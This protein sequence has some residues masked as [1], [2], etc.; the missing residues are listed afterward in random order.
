[1][2]TGGSSATW[3]SDTMP[4]ALPRLALLLALVASHLG[5]QNLTITN[6]TVVDVSTGALRRGTTVVIDGNRIVE[7]RTILG[8]DRP[9]GQVVDAKGMYVIPGL[10]D[11]HTHAYFGWQP[12]LRRQLRAAALH[13]ERH[14]RHSR[15]GERS[16][17]RAARAAARWPQHR[18]VGP[19]MVVPVRCSTARR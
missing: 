8:N 18:L 2:G 13:R 16:R 1:M 17:R 5:A 6:A 12:R 3:H 4:S 11:M 7:R 9:R 15:H 10:W 19:R 14:H